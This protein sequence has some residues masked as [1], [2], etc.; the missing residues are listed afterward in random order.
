[1]A[2]ITHFEEQALERVSLHDGIAAKFHINDVD[3]RRILQVWT[4]GR[5]DR[6]IP[7]KTS[8]TIQ[9]TEASGRELFEILRKAF[10]L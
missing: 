1:M 4:T 8:Q 5:E 10:D 6:Q 7:G 2:R 9:L 3:G